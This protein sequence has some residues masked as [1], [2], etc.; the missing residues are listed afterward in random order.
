M[1]STLTTRSSGQ[2]NIHH[3]KRYIQLASTSASCPSN[4]FTADKLT[5]N[6]QEINGVTSVITS[7]PND[8]QKFNLQTSV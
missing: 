8:L 4:K 2:A 5:I 6:N 3:N 7:S 1:T